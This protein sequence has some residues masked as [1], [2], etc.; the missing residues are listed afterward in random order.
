MLEVLEFQ[1]QQYWEFLEILINTAKQI[2]FFFKFKCFNWNKL[3]N[4]LKRNS[5][6]NLKKKSKN[7]SFFKR[8]N[9]IFPYWIVCNK[10][11]NFLPLLKMYA[12]LK[13]SVSFTA[14]TINFVNYSDCTTKVG[15]HSPLN[16]KLEIEKIAKI[17]FKVLCPLNLLL[18]NI[19]TK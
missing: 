18:Q 9:E 11:P 12:I 19:F 7:L 4:K 8:V 1:S 10:T 3:T 17:S 5:K 15:N 6:K 2:F 14:N 16:S 13:F